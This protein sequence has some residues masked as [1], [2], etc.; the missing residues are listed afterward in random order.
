[1]S[2]ETRKKLAALPFS[3][4]L[5]ILE[6]LRERDLAIGKTR[7]KIKRNRLAESLAVA[8]DLLNK[9]DN[10]GQVDVIDRILSTFHTDVPD[11]R[12]LSGVDM[13]GGSGAVW[14]VLLCPCDTEEHKKDTERFWNAMIDISREM[15][16]IGV[17]TPRSRQI[18]E[19]FQGWLKAN[20]VKHT[21][22]IDR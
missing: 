6:K 2:D 7:G 8:R 16:R 12:T 22:S 1:M 14:E 17:G 20:V 4:K 15:D 9:Y 19:T 5:K 18:A 10:P 13:W 11:Y 3:E 21:H